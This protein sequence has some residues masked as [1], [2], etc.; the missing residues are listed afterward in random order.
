MVDGK[1]LRSSVSAI[2]TFRMCP[3][4]WHWL[5]VSGLPDKPPGRGV[6]LGL[7]GHSRLEHYYKS[8]QDVLS[9]LEKLA[10]ERKFLP[11][12]NDAIKSEQGFEFMEGDVKII[13]YID[14]TELR[15]NDV[16]ITDFKYK[17][18]LDQWAAD[19][20]DLVDPESSDGVQMLG[21]IRA[22]RA[23]GMDR[24]TATVRHVSFQHTGRK[25][26]VLAE[27]TI[28]VEEGIRRWDSIV[29]TVLP[30]MSEAAGIKDSLRV[31]G[32]ENAC[33]KYGGCAFRDRCFDPMA[34]FT[35]AIREFGEAANT[36]SNVVLTASAKETDMGG[37]LDRI[38]SQDAAPTSQKIEVSASPP[39]VATVT[40]EKLA[41]IDAGL[42]LNA[43]GTGPA[44]TQAL[45]LV[46]PPDAPKSD[47]KLA[48]RLEP[49][50]V[51]APKKR[52]RKP[53]VTAAGAEIPAASTAEVDAE[54]AQPAASLFPAEAKAESVAIVPTQ[55]LNVSAGVHI[56]LGCAPMGVAAQNL[57]HH[58]K[59]VE[60]EFIEKLKL[61]LTDLRLAS[62][63]EIGFG[64]WKPLFS[65]VLQKRLPPAG[66]Y[67]VVPGDERVD[68][69][70]SAYAE[71][72]PAGSVVI[73]TF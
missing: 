43:D 1:L 46:L 40:V 35:N 73:K 9:P 42:A 54:Y 20:E 13:G 41:A 72:L 25:D 55:A 31:L 22:M 18:D 50:A 11:L 68:I 24:Q 44:P 2:N 4:K 60:K 10:F 28:P 58:V 57:I 8:K 66:H 45:P 67:L 70:V 53:K 32:N 19:A 34:R 12:P 33:D 59:A 52:G 64:K 37:I 47:P 15:E 39:P 49:E 7:E 48:A 16:A 71:V 6:K 30:K 14:L 56:Y 62:G 29:A 38:L 5:K 69:A 63:N 65:E 51:A 27:A 61:P 23:L 26:C 21:Y 36:G 17:G 3:R